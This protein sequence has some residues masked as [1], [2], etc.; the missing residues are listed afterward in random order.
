MK[1]RR[2][3]RKREAAPGGV[4]R[5]EPKSRRKKERSWRIERKRKATTKWRMAA[6][7]AIATFYN[8]KAPEKHQG[9]FLIHEKI[10][11]V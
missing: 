6:S 5:R 7:A 2:I 1:A 9:Q 4:L 3:E 10:S 11:R 8:K